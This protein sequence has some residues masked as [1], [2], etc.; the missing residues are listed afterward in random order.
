MKRMA[1]PVLVKLPH[2]GFLY[3]EDLTRLGWRDY[4]R[5][6]LGSI[7][8]TAFFFVFIALLSLTGAA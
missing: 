4:L 8:L 1:R 2:D 6:V 5:I 3:A 7:V